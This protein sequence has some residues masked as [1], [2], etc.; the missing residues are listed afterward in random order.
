MTNPDDA[1]QVVLKGGEYEPPQAMRLG[2][3]KTGSGFCT[4]GS[5]DGTCFAGSNAGQCEN[6][7]SSASGM[8]LSPGSNGH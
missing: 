6:P 7:G 4:P 3:V 2:D 5:G 1:K 8:C